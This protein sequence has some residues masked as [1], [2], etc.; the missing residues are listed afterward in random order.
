M[1][2][3]TVFSKKR[4]WQHCRTRFSAGKSMP[5]P[6]IST[7][8]MVQRSSS[9]TL[10]V[11]W[12]MCTNESIMLPET[13]FSKKRV[14][15]HCRTR[16]SNSGL[17]AIVPK[18]QKIASDNIVK[19]DGARRYLPTTLSK[20][21]LQTFRQHCQKVTRTRMVRKIFSPKP[22][23]RR[24]QGVRLTPCFPFYRERGESITPSGHSLPQS[25]TDQSGILSDERSPWPLPVQERTSPSKT[26]GKSWAVNRPFIV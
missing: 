12:E 2:P 20:C 16:F 10:F 18:V 17:P 1:L 11:F 7:A 21:S 14:W 13:V 9:A 5:S 4:V 3:E 8:A 19:S 24:K 6:A 26:Q 15:Q 22:E 25:K 23:K